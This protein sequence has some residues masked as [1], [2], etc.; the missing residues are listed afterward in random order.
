MKDGNGVVV[1]YNEDGTEDF[2]TVTN[3][4]DGNGVVVFYKA[5]GTENFR[6]TYKDGEKV[7][8]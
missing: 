2:R 8:D 1:H 6:V 7:E 3:M 4:K 5:D